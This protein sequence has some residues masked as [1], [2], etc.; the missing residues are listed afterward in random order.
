MSFVSL[1]CIFP[2]ICFHSNKPNVLKQKLELMWSNFITCLPQHNW[3]LHIKSWV[4]C[5]SSFGGF[6]WTR[7]SLLSYSLAAEKEPFLH[8]NKTQKWVIQ[9]RNMPLLPSSE[10]IQAPFH[11]TKWHRPRKFPAPAFPT[12]WAQWHFQMRRQERRYCLSRLD[13]WTGFL[14]RPMAACVDTDM[15]GCFLTLPQ[16]TQAPQSLTQ[17][18]E[19]N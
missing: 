5:P 4:S 8:S 13:W 7:F 6:C 10:K 1:I 9:D 14:S 18:P 19:Y 3:R 2:Y 15:W 16:K 11:H 17:E 12:K